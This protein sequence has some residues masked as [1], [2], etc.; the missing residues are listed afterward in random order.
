MDSEKGIISLVIVISSIKSIGILFLLAPKTL[1]PT[2]KERVF[3][4][5]RI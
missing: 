4:Y 1:A 3:K 2:F 5:L